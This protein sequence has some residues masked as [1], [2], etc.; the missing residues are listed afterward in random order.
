MHSRGRRGGRVVWFEDDNLCMDNDDG[1]VN[2]GAVN[3]RGTT[4]GY[5]RTFRGDDFPLFGAANNA[6]KN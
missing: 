4:D 5:G 1:E 6:T 2:P 3:G